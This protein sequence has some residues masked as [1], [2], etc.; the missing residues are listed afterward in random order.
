MGGR[1]VAVLGPGG[2][3]GLVAALLA[4]DG[5]DVV[6]LGREQTTHVIAAR[7][8]TVRSAQ[9]GD[10][11]ADV[12]ARPTLDRPVDLCVVAV[13]ATALPDAL[14]RAPRDV[15][16]DGLVVPLLNGT[17][18]MDVLRERYDPAQV[19]AG[20]IRVEAA[21]TAPGR[22]VHSSPFVQVDLAS[23]TAPRTRLDDATTA[24]T[25]AGVQARVL[26]DEAR[27]LW[28]KLAFLA[29]FALLT[30]RYRAPIGEVRTTHRD[31]LIAL[32]HEV[33]AISR[34]AGGTGDAA[35]A[36]ARYEQFPADARSSMQRDAEAGNPLELDAIGGAVL[37]AAERYHLDA[38][39]TRTLV[40]ALS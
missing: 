16:G 2:V 39:H 35:T 14:D 32:V 37:R 24:L 13:K 6:V 30:T 28:D 12:D 38:L 1:T 27:A 15:L 3:G 26:D 25:S 8:L 33:A 4:R 17:E 7:G 21:R 36:L 40:S 29:P 10:L 23:T 11:H 31:E 19:A 18:H 5:N 22:I 9:L 20:V 34:A